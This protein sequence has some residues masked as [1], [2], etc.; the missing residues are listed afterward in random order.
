MP[1]IMPVGGIEPG[2]SELIAK[3]V[4][5][6]DTDAV[7]QKMESIKILKDLRQQ[8][9]EGR[10]ALPI[11]VESITEEIENQRQQLE[12]AIAECGSLA[13]IPD[14]AMEELAEDDLGG[15]INLEEGG[16]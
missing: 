4:S 6:C 1:E 5:H 11:T 7:I 12:N 8:V 16:M 10:T 2:V 15:E 9:V 13:G 3:E 14:E